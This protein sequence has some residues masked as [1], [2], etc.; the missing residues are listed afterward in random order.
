MS[1][2][3]APA[4]TSTPLDGIHLP[5][6]T[7]DRQQLQALYAHQAPSEVFDEIRPLDLLFTLHYNHLLATFDMLFILSP[8]QYV[9]LGIEAILADLTTDERVADISKKMRCIRTRTWFEKRFNRD[10]VPPQEC[11]VEEL[12]NGG[13][14]TFV[15]YRPAVDFGLELL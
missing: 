9:K 3:G 2:L 8:A 4:K 1:S 13:Q 6:Q 12:E 5:Q 14:R 7:F 15:V 10:D 11:P